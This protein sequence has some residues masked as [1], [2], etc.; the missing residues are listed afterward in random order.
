MTTAL[1]RG[2][3][4][5][6][7]WGSAALVAIPPLLTV[8]T[9]V[10]TIGV[11]LSE[12]ATFS[13]VAVLPLALFALGVQL[14][15]SVA[16]ARGE[17]PRAALWTVLA[18]ILV[19]YLPLRWFGWNWLVLQGFV[20]ASMPVA[21]NGKPAAVAA[22]APLVGTAVAI[23][24]V[25]LASPGL[26]GSP[27]VGHEVYDIVYFVLWNCAVAA[28]AYGAARLVRLTHQL[29]E[30]RGELAAAALWGERLR[31]SR[32]LHDLLGHSLSAVSLKGELAIRL[33]R[34]DPEAA[35]S[36]M[37]S[38]AAVA[39]D[40]LGGVL[41]ISHDERDSSL[42]AELDGALLLLAA[43]GIVTKARIDVDG[44]G[45]RTDRMLAWAVREGVA[46]IIRHS[47]ARDATITACRIDGSIVLEITN[48]GASPPGP[49]GAGLNGLTERAQALAGSVA[50]SNEADRFQLVVRLPGDAQ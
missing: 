21:L 36:E 31:V 19:T 48:D 39:R 37:L 10:V 23:V 43:A 15:H 49:R 18:L 22:F 4:V 9:V 34:S 7:D 13:L 50:A 6:L 27:G 17:R 20:M 24:L 33:L 40:A 2:F 42:R 29:R 8:G 46:N 26:L 14:R 35:R 47:A 1:S 11:G 12:P 16:L 44:V 25:G 41:G 32:D 30:T 45:A 28:G 38:V 5:P 3:G